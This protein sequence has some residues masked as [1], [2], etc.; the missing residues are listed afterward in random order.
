[1]YPRY[2]FSTILVL[3]E[4]LP[5]KCNFKTRV[6]SQQ[7]SMIIIN[8]NYQL[9][10]SILF[11]TKVIGG[12]IWFIYILKW[13]GIFFIEW[14]MWWSWKIQISCVVESLCWYWKGWCDNCE[15]WELIQMW[16]CEMPNVCIWIFI[17]KCE[18]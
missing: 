9:K 6:F 2:W 13:V 7:T 16:T 10:M 12:I 17:D 15:Y 8:L 5:R 3:K 18:C 1:M 11:F 4:K 14:K